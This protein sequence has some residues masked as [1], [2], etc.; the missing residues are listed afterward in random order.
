[1]NVLVI[2]SGGREH[3]IC[4]KLY[5]SENVDRI[6]CA[7]GNA[8]TKKIST[9]VDIQVDEI[10]KLIEFAKDK[11]VDLTVVGPEGPLV[12]GIVD[13]FRENG[14]LIFGPNKESA[15][16]EGSK[17][18]TKEFMFKHD[19]PTANY[20]KFDDYHTA[21]DAI[22]SY[23]YPL[24][25]KADGLCAGKGVVICETPIEALY[26]LKDILIEK[27][28]GDEGNTVVI[29]EFLRGYEASVFCICSSGKLHLLGTAKD[30]KNIYEGDKGPNTGGVG[31]FSPNILLDDQ[32]LETIQNEIIPQIEKGLIEDDLAFS[33]VLFIGFMVTENGPKILEFNV[34]FGDPETQVLLPR[35]ESDFFQVL[36]KAAKGE[37]DS[38]DIVLSDKKTMTVIMTSGGYPASFGK[39]YEISGLDELDSIEDLYII[40]NGTECKEEKIVTSGGR[41]LSITALCDTLG[42]CR[43]LIYKNIDSIKFTNSYYRKDIGNIHLQ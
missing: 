43:D 40:H 35:L 2:G 13:S 30:Y 6:Y 14:L 9:N 21:V 8:G 33:G 38:K 20:D 17:S 23:D 12:E 39:G 19:I 4:R 3:A 11:K 36:Y 1:M 22:K 41:V 34:R 24:V 31:S 16:L 28:F 7:P 26:T 25:I 29:E 32:T 18:F 15:K 42:E 37:L 27:K 10:D 5:E